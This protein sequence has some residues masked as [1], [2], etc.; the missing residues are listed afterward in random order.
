MI[1]GS[2]RPSHT[3]RG[4]RSS[5]MVAISPCWSVAVGR[6]RERG[7]HTVSH[8]GRRPPCLHFVSFRRH[9]D[10]NGAMSHTAALRCLA[11]AVLIFPRMGAESCEQ[12][13][14]R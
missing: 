11:A 8:G 3:D 9:V 6:D 12:F 4:V 10:L 13:G 1:D 7:H 2:E 14:F 5:C